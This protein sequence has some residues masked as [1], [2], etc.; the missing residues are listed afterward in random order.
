MNKIQKFLQKLV[1]RVIEILK[2][3]TIDYQVS[4]KNEK[5]DEEKIKFEKAILR[6]LKRFKIGGDL[7]GIQTI[8]I[9]CNCNEY[10]LITIKKLII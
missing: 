3:R 10:P 6:L 1:I 7:K 5:N 2:I 9:N 8:E 4:L